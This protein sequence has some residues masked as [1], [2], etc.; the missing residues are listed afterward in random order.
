[1][2][3]NRGKKGLNEEKGGRQLLNATQDAIATPI[4]KGIYSYKS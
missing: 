2:G 3:G 4:R 1:L